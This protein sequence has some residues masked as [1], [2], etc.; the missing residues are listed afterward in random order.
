MQ[1]ITNRFYVRQESSKGII[2]N[3][4]KNDDA[5][6]ITCSSLGSQVLPEL[7]YDKRIF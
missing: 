5:S 2:N 6:V 7:D 3:L 4:T 1:T